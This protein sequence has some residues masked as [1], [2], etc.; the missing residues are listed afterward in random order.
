MLDVRKGGFS[1]P[2]LTQYN[3][4]KAFVALLIRMLNLFNEQDVY[5][6]KKIFIFG[7]E[8]EKVDLRAHIH[9]VLVE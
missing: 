7:F 1:P 9:V 6:R 4:D 2:L 3:G 5:V 8:T